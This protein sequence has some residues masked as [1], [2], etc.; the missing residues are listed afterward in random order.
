M[1][2]KFILVFMFLILLFISMPSYSAKEDLLKTDTED[3][4]IFIKDKNG[5][6]SYSWTFDKEEYSQNEFDFDLGISFSSNKKNMIDLL[7]GK[8]IKKKYISFNHHGKLPSSAVIKTDVEDTFK[9]VKTLKLY[10][11]NESDETIEFID[12]VEVK[13]GYVT[14]EIEHCSE[15][16]LTKSEIKSA[17]GNKNNGGIIIIGMIIVITGLVGYTLFNNKR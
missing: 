13:N 15:Y 14:F 16:F 12:E 6:F 9:N 11:Y 17:E 4:V 2:N 1:K 3:E 5:K 10:Y 7:S 8:N